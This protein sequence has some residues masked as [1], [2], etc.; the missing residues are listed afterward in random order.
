MIDCI[1][2]SLREKFKT[3]E[4][5]NRMI[6]DAG[7]AYFIL[8]N[9][10]EQMSDKHYCPE[11]G[12]FAAIGTIHAAAGMIHNLLLSYCAIAPA[13]SICGT[14]DYFQKDLNALRE[15]MDASRTMQTFSDLLSHTHGSV[16]ARAENLPADEAI[17]LLEKEVSA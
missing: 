1:T 5:F 17:A 7:S 12:L 15:S 11:E 13:E 4:L 14:T 8:A 6:D 3:V 2:L 9:L 10:E 16:R